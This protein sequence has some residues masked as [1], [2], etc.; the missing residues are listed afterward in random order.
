[1]EIGGVRCCP[2]SQLGLNIVHRGTSSWMNGIRIHVHE[3]KLSACRRDV[4]W[5]GK[6]GSHKA[7]GRH[8]HIIEVLDR[9]LLLVRG[10]PVGHLG[11]YVVNEVFCF[12]TKY[13]HSASFLSSPLALHHETS[14][15]PSL[16][17]NG[18]STVLIMR[19]TYIS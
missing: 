12:S 7:E 15:I 13:V 1:M 2:L 11:L 3:S 9:M 19:T 16:V 17:R 5:D 8:G 14:M 18:Q 6:D 10:G 4:K